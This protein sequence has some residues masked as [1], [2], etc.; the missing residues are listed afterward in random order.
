MTFGELRD[1]DCVGIAPKVKIFL[2]DDADH[3]AAARELTIPTVGVHGFEYPDDAPADSADVHD[4]R[5]PPGTV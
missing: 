2:P 5:T 3:S 4:P 1:Y